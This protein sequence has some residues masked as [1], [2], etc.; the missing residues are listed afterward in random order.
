MCPE[1]YCPKISLFTNYICFTRYM[2]NVYFW[3]AFIVIICLMPTLTAWKIQHVQ[4]FF[5]RV[6]LFCSCICCSLYWDCL[7]HLLIGL[8]IDD[9][10]ANSFH[11]FVSF[12]SGLWCSCGRCVVMQHVHNSVCCKE[13]EA[14]QQK[15]LHAGVDQTTFSCFTEHPWCKATCLNP[16]TLETAYY[17]FK[18]QYGAGAIEGDMARYYMYS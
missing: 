16:G 17:H 18:Q 4:S 11:H 2:Q 1:S 15:V 7:V 3:L 5:K 10:V 12:T 14:M 8:L 6:N 13:V 9:F